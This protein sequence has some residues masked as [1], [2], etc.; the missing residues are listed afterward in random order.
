M[1]LHITHY[2]FCFFTGLINIYK[3]I[4]N[5]VHHLLRALSLQRPPNF[6][7]FLPHWRGRQCVNMERKQT[8]VLDKLGFDFQPW[9]SLAVRP[10]EKFKKLAN[11][12]WKLVSGTV[13][14]SFYKLNLPQRWKLGA[15]VLRKLGHR[16]TLSN[17]HKFTQARVWQNREETQVSW[18]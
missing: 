16:K 8:S 10:W 2:Y 15:T 3:K 12:Y 13:L 7:S 18:I 17:L 14:G 1:P 4:H 9:N 5:T 11:V 6:S